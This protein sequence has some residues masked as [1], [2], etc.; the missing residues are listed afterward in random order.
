MI[1]HG[2][3]NIDVGLTCLKFPT[4]KLLVIDICQ[5]WGRRYGVRL[6]CLDTRSR[7]DIVTGGN[8]RP[9]L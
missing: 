1:L 7:L 8:V 2:P 6:L 5:D 3:I 9:C 4:L